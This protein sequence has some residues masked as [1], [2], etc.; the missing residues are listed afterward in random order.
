[1]K[2]N[3]N[4]NGMISNIGKEREFKKIQHSLGGSFMRVERR[5]LTT[6]ETK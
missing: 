4:E 3:G 6:I 2:S 5:T 1:M